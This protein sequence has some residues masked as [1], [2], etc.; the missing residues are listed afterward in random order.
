VILCLCLSPAIDVTYRVERLVPGATVRVAG[1]TD[2]PGGKAVNVA[3]VLH[4]LGEPVLVI[5]PVGG[6][7]GAEL[8]HGLAAM[9]IPAR[10]VPD[11]ATT[12]RTVT[13]VE[14][15][16]E[17]TSLV[18]PASVTRWPAIQAAFE[19]SLDDARAVVI[20]GG[21]PAGVPEQGLTALIAAA[22]ARGIPVVADTSGPALLEV[23]EAGADVVKP[24]A[25]EL[26]HVTHDDEPIRAARRLTDLHGTVVVVSRGPDG[27]LATAPH[28]TWEARPDAAVTGNPTG[29]GDALVAGLARGLARDRAALDHPEDVLRDAVALSIA[30]VHA[31]TAGDFD[32]EAYADAPDGVTVTA[33]DGVR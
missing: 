28:G 5:A 18:E 3:R 17:A 8:G 1:V 24:N 11:E 21:V 31:H 32:H 16:G 9:G 33:L 2:R 13:V 10:L 25:E 19:D 29:A 20:S 12:R 6:D 22:K 26:A 7:T 15:H 27:V 4:A 30:S 14:E 23:I